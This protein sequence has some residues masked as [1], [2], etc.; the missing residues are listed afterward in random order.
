M[1]YKD[2]YR[3]DTW[4]NKKQFYLLVLP[5][6][7]IAHPLELNPVSSSFFIISF[8]IYFFL[9]C[10]V[11]HFPGKGNILSNNFNM[12]NLLVC[13][14]YMYNTLISRMKIMYNRENIFK[15]NIFL[16]MTP[17]PIFSEQQL[18][19]HGIKYFLNLNMNVYWV[20]ADTTLLKFS[21]LWVLPIEH[22]VLVYLNTL[23]I[24]P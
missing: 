21:L 16:I 23:E 6:V 14:T 9:E 2:K 15:K 7:L 18:L 3:L 4:R 19:Q 17:V 8:P 1:R 20:F 11:V 10:V 22:A 12:K 5:L 13:C 24:V